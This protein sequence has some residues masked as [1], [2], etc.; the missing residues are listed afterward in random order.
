MSKGN[1]ITQSYD[2]EAFQRSGAAHLGNEPS[3]KKVLRGSSPS[4]GAKQAAWD[5]IRFVCS[6]RAYHLQ[7]ES[8]RESAEA[9]GRLYLPEQYPKPR[10][11]QYALSQYVIGNPDVPKQFQT[12]MQAADDLLPAARVR[13]VTPVGQLLY[14]EQI[15]AMETALYHRLPPAQA[16]ADSQEV[17]QKAIDQILAPTSRTE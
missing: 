3:F 6:D 17:V 4:S 2:R 10:I 15:R 14:N 16:L 1:R 11:N 8:D 5:F 7:M 9:D 13:P 12:A